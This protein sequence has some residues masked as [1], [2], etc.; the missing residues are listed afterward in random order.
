MFRQLLELLEYRIIFGVAGNNYRIKKLRKL[1]VKI[2]NNCI[3]LNTSY[4]T[5]PYLIEIGDH[6]VIASGVRFV[7]HDGSVW[8]YRDQ[9]PAI[10]SFGQIKVGNNCFIGIDSI[11]LPNTE[12]GNNCIIGA[13]TVIRGKIPDD[14]VVMGNPAKVIMKSSLLGKMLLANKNTL[15]IKNLS[16][17]EKKA[18]LIK[19]FNLNDISNK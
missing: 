2:G 6:V 18:F 8:I 13:G 14:S 9:Y 11:I 5:E 7:T 12:I 16:A 17:K 19:H 15:H 1:G 4:N 3:I 10:D